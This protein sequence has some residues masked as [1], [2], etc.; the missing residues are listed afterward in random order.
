M[1][2]WFFVFALATSLASAQHSTNGFGYFLSN[3]QVTIT[4]YT[5][6]GGAV[7]VPAIIEAAPVTALGDY[8]FSERTNVTSILLPTTLTNFGAGAFD[9]CRSLESIAIPEGTTVLKMRTFNNCDKLTNVALPSTLLSIGNWAFNDCDILESIVFPNNLESIG[10]GTVGL[11]WNLKTVNI[12]NSLTNIGP[13]NFY[14]CPFL[15]SINVS[16][17][18]PAYTSTDG[19]LYNKA[20]SS[21]LKFPSKKQVASYSLPSSLN[22]IA[23]HAFM[24]NFYLTN[25]SV[26]QG[27]TNIGWW[28][29]T[30]CKMLQSV[31]IPS[32]VTNISYNNFQQCYK[33]LAINVDESNPVFFSDN[34]VLFLN[35]SYWT[36]M[37]NYIYQTNLYRFPNGV[38][39]NYNV[40]NYVNVINWQAFEYSTS[41]T[42]VYIP[43]SVT[44]IQGFAFSQCINLTNV[45]L[46]SN[47]N[48]LSRET[49]SWCD[50]IQS[51]VI[52][53]LVTN[54]ESAPFGYFKQPKAV[55]F[56]GNAPTRGTY[57]NHSSNSIF[58][59][60]PGTLGWT[61]F[62]SPY[63]QPGLPPISI[64]SF[65]SNTNNNSKFTLRFNTFFSLQYTVQK[66]TNLN[67]WTNVH[68]V[69]GDNTEKEFQSN[70]TDRG[71]FKVI[72]E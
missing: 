61:S 6:P 66:T 57:F 15:E 25:L 20:R 72:Q 54:I 52:P 4:N 32:S 23:D 28:S 5:G 27:V 11:C 37:T 55:Y 10:T 64:F 1:V 30:R 39:G 69:Q 42:S 29:I 24:D 59:Y 13:N 26:P 41:L 62:N 44:N 19:I 22:N 43:N 33:L 50:K 53:H 51:I 40:P 71:F 63:V 21:I 68:V 12:P 34:G 18:N 46:P 60:K 3:N 17:S 9:N 58:Y 56:L 67:T 31:Q 36:S 35:Q 7:S 38:A 47:L 45:I 16:T 8:A 14:A 49:F 70:I 48:V 2:H 65:L